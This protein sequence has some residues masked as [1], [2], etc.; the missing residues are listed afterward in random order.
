MIISS[1]TITSMKLVPPLDL[2]N[3]LV[4][5]IAFTAVTNLLDPFS[6]VSSHWKEGDFGDKFFPFQMNLDSKRMLA[7]LTEMTCL[8][9]IL[10]PKT[11]SI[12]LAGIAAM[13]GR[14][15]LIHAQTSSYKAFF[16]GIGFVSALLLWIDMQDFPARSKRIDSHPSP[17]TTKKKAL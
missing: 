7:G 11:R 12:G 8:F 15:T 5:M 16:V 2:F 13:Y 17:A 10:K 4:L 6:I 14:A 3:Y 1:S 9:L